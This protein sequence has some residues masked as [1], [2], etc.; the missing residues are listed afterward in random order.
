MFNCK[1]YHIATVEQNSSE[2]NKVSQT[3]MHTYGLS[4][5]AQ[6]SDHT[7]TDT[8]TCLFLQITKTYTGEMTNSKTKVD[9]KTGFPHVKE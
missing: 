3:D 9:G 4:H 8:D 2:D 6:R 7:V 1:L 5:R